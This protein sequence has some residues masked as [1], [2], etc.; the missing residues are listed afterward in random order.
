LTD[1][2]VQIYNTTIIGDFN[3]PNSIMGGTS[4]QEINKE[5]A[6]LHHILD[7]MALTSTH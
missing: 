2:K 7:Q 3:I 1:L 6:E 4:G 5:K